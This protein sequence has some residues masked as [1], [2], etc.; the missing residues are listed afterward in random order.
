MIIGII[1][2]LFFVINKKQKIYFFFVQALI[3]LSS[4][5]E[6]LTVFMIGGLISFL[7]DNSS[8]E[9]NFFLEKFLNFLEI[10]IKLKLPK[11]SLLQLV[12]NIICSEK[13]LSINK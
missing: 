12:Y 1:K 8:N 9:K 5:M 2:N 13:W 4:L 7:S 6:I 11:I 3:F 10:K